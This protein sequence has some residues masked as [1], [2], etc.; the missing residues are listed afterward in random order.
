MLTLFLAK[1]FFRDKRGRGADKRGAS[2]PAI[3]IA[4]AGVAVGLAVM[5][6]SVGVVKGFQREVRGKLSG[7][8]AHLTLV[9]EAY[10][11]APEDAP[12]V[13]DKSV[14]DKVRHIPH[15]TGVQRFSEKI[16]VLKT[17]D[18]FAGVVLKGIGADYDQTF[19]KSC[20]REGRWPSFGD[21]KA[22]QEVAVSR[23]MADMLHLKVGDGVFSYFFSN[24]IKQRRLKIAAIYET[25]LPQFDK[26]YVIAPIATVNRLN[27]WS[28]DLASGLE[29]RLD[30]MASLD[31]VQA[32]LKRDFKERRDAYGHGYGTLSI[33]ENPRTSGTLS[34]LGL[35]DF[36]VLVILVIMLCV[37]GFTMV[38]GLLIL[39][40]ERTST[41][42]LLKAIGA[43]NRTI[44][45]TFLWYA[46][47]II[48]RGLLIGDAIGLALLAAQDKLH[49]VRLNPAVYYVDAVP[50]EFDA[51][52]IVGLNVAALVV[53]LLA[54]TLPSCLVSRVQ[55]AKAIRFD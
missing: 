30:N 42:G 19:L 46:A 24:T 27:G 51:A 2:G 8:A 3:R 21:P 49:L 17:E 32:C 41:I 10:A 15:V 52:W 36:N 6:A 25:Q 37:S 45:R 31:T 9:N 26:N 1:G 13:A 43:T 47:L 50:V 11:G 33:R 55:P 20:V 12:V 29:I 44:R 40:L 34:W 16:G 18:D 38:S 54:L 28:D 23:T 7:F 14:A 5:I 53:T 48:G 22:A 39:I 4:T 35:L